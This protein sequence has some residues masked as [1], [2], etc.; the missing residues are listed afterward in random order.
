MNVHATNSVIGFQNLSNSESTSFDEIFNAR[1]FVP[2]SPLVTDFLN[3]V[4]EKLMAHALLR[5]FPDV[6]TFAFW[7]RKASVSKMKTRYVDRERRL[8]RGV[9]FHVAPSNVP[10]NFAYSLASGLL[11]GN[12]N[13]VRVPSAEFIQVQMIADVFEELLKTQSFADLRNHICLIR[14]DKSQTQV[15]SELSRRCDVRVI[16]GGDRSIQEIRQSP[17]SQRSYDVTFADRYSL[18]VIDADGYLSENDFSKIALRFYNDTYLFDQNA[19]T[20]PHLIYWLGSISQV[21]QAKQMFWG[22]LQALVESKYDLQTVSAVDKLTTAYMFVSQ[23]TKS[24]ITK[25]Q[26]NLITRIKIGSLDSGIEKWRGKWGCFFEYQATNLDALAQIVN[27][28]FQTLSYIG[29]TPTALE[30][31]VHEKRMTGIDRIV[32]VGQTLDFALDWDGYDLIS[33]FSRVI[34]VI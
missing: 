33:T 19:C 12:A 23:N 24:Q 18:C 13:I 34:S 11:A 3:Q 2:F 16:W 4:S 15:T 5:E 31:L 10:V 17:L 29:M 8:G 32:P 28:R 20:A 6:A 9:I 22:E 14:Y 1:P 30:A 21:E 7:C 25:S 26:N 27:Q